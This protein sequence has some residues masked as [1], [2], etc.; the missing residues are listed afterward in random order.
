[1]FRL[2]AESWRREF[3]IKF[4]AF[5]VRGQPGHPNGR[6][7]LSNDLVSHIS[8]KLEQKE[9]KKAKQNK[10]KKILLTEKIPRLRVHTHNIYYRLYF[11]ECCAIALL[12]GCCSREFFFFWPTIISHVIVLHYIRTCGKKRISPCGVLL[13]S[14]GSHARHSSGGYIIDSICVCSVHAW[15]ESIS[16]FMG[17][18][19][20][21]IWEKTP[22]V[23]SSHVDP[24]TVWTG[25]CYTYPFTLFDM[26]GGPKTMPTRPAVSFCENIFFFFL[27]FLFFPPQ[28]FVAR[29]ETHSRKSSEF[30][31]L[32]VDGRRIF[33]GFFS[34]CFV[35]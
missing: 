29:R 18:V 9:R 30:L 3:G 4:S 34:V 5:A 2:P 21:D 1:M 12:W 20:R 19:G 31:D 14:V 15:G 16:L 22:E 6:G 8:F 24:E 28:Y 26:C 27:V 32:P 10:T 25:H 33:G 7:D 13:A 17:N 11:V 23:F 35:E